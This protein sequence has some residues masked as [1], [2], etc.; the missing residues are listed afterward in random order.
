MDPRTRLSEIAN[1]YQHSVVLLTACKLGVFAALGDR[2]RVASELAGELKIDRRGIETVLLA[3]TAD[4]FLEREGRAFRIAPGYAPLLLPDSPQTQ[5]SIMNHSYSCLLRWA[6]LETV[7]K[8][9]RPARDTG[10]MGGGELR[11]FI[12]GMANISRESSADVASKVDLSGFRRMLDVG[13]GPATSSIVFARA[14]PNLHCV[15]FDL[16]G[17]IAI[18]HEEI[19]KAGLADRI[20]TRVADYFEDDFGKGFDLIYIS[21]IIHSMG[22]EDTAMLARKSYDALD[23]GGALVVKDFFLD[24]ERTSPAFGAFFSVNMLVGTE[25]GRSYTLNE[26]R[27]ILERAGF[28]GFRTVEVAAASRLLIARKG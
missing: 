26:T 4:G 22:P 15:V 9:G 20:E 14:N 25:H 7:L 17:A 6:Q 13:G 19:E 16:E 3:L 23:E 21:N 28:G 2:A 18:A 8:T 1:G 24:D 10:R 27:E 12:C 11:D 5:A